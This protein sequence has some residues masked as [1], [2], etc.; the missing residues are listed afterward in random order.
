DLESMWFLSN[1][2]GGPGEIAP[3]IHALSNHLLDTPWPKV[4]RGKALMR[5]ALARPLDAD[6]LLAAFDDTT[7]AAG[8]ALPDTGVGLELEERLSAIRIAPHGGYGTRCSTVLAIGEDGRAT[9]GERTWREDG[10]AGGAVRH[11]F[12]VASASSPGAGS[13]PPRT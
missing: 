1:R 7:T 12:T 8:A 5:E 11:V 4:E 13:P 6:A 2:G 3:G 9:F 10:G